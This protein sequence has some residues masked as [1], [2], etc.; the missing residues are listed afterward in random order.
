[1]FRAVSD[2]LLVVEVADVPARV[3]RRLDARAE[4]PRG[5]AGRPGVPEARH[6]EARAPEHADDAAGGRAVDVDVGGV[7]DA[8][9]RDGHAGPWARR[10]EG[11]VRAEPPRVMRPVAI[12]DVGDLLHEQNVD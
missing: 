3:R 12:A 9:Q 8:V 4:R 7:M 11:S 10:L 2:L 1:M 6:R 5:P